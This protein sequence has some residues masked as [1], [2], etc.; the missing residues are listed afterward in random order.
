VNEVLAGDLL[1]LRQE[2]GGPR[3]SLFLPLSPGSPRSTKTRIRA[4][5]LLNR[6]EKALR[7]DGLPSAKVTDLIGR[8]RRALDR[9]RPLNENHRGLAV[10]AD[11]DDVRTYDVPV[12]LPELAA[13]GDRFALTPL[14]PTI[15][16]QGRFFLLTLTQDRIRLLEG[17]A[18]TVEPVDLEGRELAAW[19]TMPPPRAPQVH[20]FLADRGGQG[21]RTV[22]HGVGS[23]SDDRKVRALQHFRGT[24]RA[25]REVLGEDQPPLVLA[26]VRQ[27]QALY[28]AVST[29]PH[30]LE[31]GIDGNPELINPDELHRQAWAVAEPELRRGAATA[32]RRYRELQGTG[33]T[34]SDPEDVRRAA[35]DGRVETLLV[36]ESACAWGP[37]NGRPVLR[38]G[39]APQAEERLEATVV[40]TLGGNG[41]VFVVP[42]A[43]LPDPSPTAAVLRY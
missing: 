28:R 29:Y 10:F 40:A 43:D 37:G 6:A 8:A 15:N 41:A 16:L 14:L 26:G 27:L 18:L 20:A 11:A 17:T 4:K 31:G 7:S 36:A 9:A 21:A 39:S 35:V 22:F 32:V 1:R 24:D 30:L 13:V 23:A 5:N 42:D 12:R 2:A 3:L 19:T 38:L 25:L 33:R 34:R